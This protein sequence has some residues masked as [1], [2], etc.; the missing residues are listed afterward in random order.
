MVAPQPANH[1]PSPPRPS[2]FVQFGPLAHKGHLAYLRASV[3]ELVAAGGTAHCSTPLPLAAFPSGNF[4][5]P[6][7]I[8]GVAPALALN[9]I[10]GPVATMHPFDTPEEAVRLANMAPGFLLTNIYTK[11]VDAGML[12]GRSCRAGMVMLN[13]VGFGFDTGSSGAEPSFSFWGSSGWG[14]DGPLE[15]LVDFFTGQRVVGL[16]GSMQGAFSNGGGGASASSSSSSTPSTGAAPAAGGAI[17]TP[18][19]AAAPGGAAGTQSAPAAVRAAMLPV[20]GVGSK[21]GLDYRRKLFYDLGVVHSDAAMAPGM[22]RV[23]SR[24]GIA[25]AAAST[26]TTELA[27]SGPASAVAGLTP[28]AGNNEGARQPSD[29]GGEVRAPAAAASGTPSSGAP[30]GTG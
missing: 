9:E 4:F 13:G 6:T 18:G 7:I 29:A 2:L 27:A 10:F 19:A 14:K 17:A 25:A 26:A 3:A 1:P 12:L 15:T 30:R 8:T 22:Q 5:A 23:A 21:S 11:N 28:V 16:N 20:R 24:D